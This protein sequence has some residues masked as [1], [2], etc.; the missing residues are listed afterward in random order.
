LD[1]GGIDRGLYTRRTGQGVLCIGIV[2]SV[3]CVLCFINVTWGI[4]LV[5]DIL[6]L[7]R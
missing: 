3:L 2:C 5:V 1:G 6:C 4:S 7:G